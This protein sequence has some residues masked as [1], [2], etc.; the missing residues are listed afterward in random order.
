[1]S[2]LIHKLRTE[3]A[4]VVATVLAALALVGVNV[5][6]GNADAIT[7]LVAAGAPLIAGLVTRSKVA[8]VG[9]GPQGIDHL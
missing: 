8:P 4:M 1:M 7:Q 5:S 9:P 2:T 3:P 6:D